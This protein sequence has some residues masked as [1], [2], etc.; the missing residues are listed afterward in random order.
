MVLR[1]SVMSGE[2]RLLR[3]W[4]VLGCTLYNEDR[5]AGTIVMQLD[6]PRIHRLEKVRY[7]GYVISDK[8]R[9]DNQSSSNECCF[10]SAISTYLV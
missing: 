2:R 9:G 8:A 3:L 10:T 5:S 1:H 7:M 6:Y 4:L